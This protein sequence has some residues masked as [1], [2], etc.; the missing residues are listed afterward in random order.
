MSLE[1]VVEIARGE[2]GYTEYPAGSNRTKY[3]QAY[4]WDGVPW[5]CIFLW[6][7][8][9]EA[10]ESEAFYGG[11]KTASCGTLYRWYRERG[12]TVPPEEARPGDILILD[13]SGKGDTQHCGLLVQTVGEDTGWYR[14]I[15]GNTS[16]G[17]EGSQASG[18]CVAQRLRN[19]QQVLGVCR[20]VYTHMEAKPD[21]TGHWAEE[22]IRWAMGKG[23]MRGYE[24]GTW[25]PERAV[26]MA[27]LAAVLKRLEGE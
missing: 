3:G 14:T 25:Q 17:P 4:A 6:W 27:E 5:C 15:E 18:G 13:F 9:R 12:L 21:W 24:D 8:F 23:L 19:R 2:L 26:T 10:G 11:G 16:P 7:C 20:P 1:R 22:S